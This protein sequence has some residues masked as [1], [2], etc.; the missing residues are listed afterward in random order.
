M[1][2]NNR[3]A[4]TWFSIMARVTEIFLEGAPDKEQ[5]P[6]AVIFY[7]SV[8]I[9]ASFMDPFKIKNPAN[10]GLLFVI[11]TGFKPVTF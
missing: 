3:S 10:A 1:R 11:P 4:V 7:F 8:S 5:P 9:E 6:L 2:K